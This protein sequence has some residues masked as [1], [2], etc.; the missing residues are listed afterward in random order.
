MYLN[1]GHYGKAQILSP[2]T[3][4]EMTRV[5]VNLDDTPRGLGWMGRSR[6][7]SSSDRWFGPHSYEHTG[8]TGTM[9][10]IDP[11]HDCYV[12]L[13]TNRVHPDGRGL[14]VDLRR[15][16]V[17]VVA[18]AIVEGVTERYLPAPSQPPQ[19]VAR[20]GDGLR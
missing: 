20:R 3:V 5:H 6:C 18:S 9:F 7:G 10:W 13:L 11:I 19:P 17:T 8:F 2:G 15:R 14:V 16:V 4:N 1:G 12:I